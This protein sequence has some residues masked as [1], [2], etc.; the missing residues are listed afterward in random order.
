M[1]KKTL[2]HDEESFSD[3]GSDAL[4]DELLNS[5]EDLATTDV[6]NDCLKAAQDKVLSKLDPDFRSIVEEELAGLCKRPQPPRS[7]LTDEVALLI[8]LTALRTEGVAT[9]DGK[10]LIQSTQPPP[11]LKI[12]HK[13]AERLLQ[14]DVAAI[15]EL[16]LDT[17]RNNE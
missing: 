16:D 1:A 11:M 13:I 3:C 8:F 9:E 17:K 7:L 4:W 10:V 6:A 2:I 15:C 5:A 12:P 14:N